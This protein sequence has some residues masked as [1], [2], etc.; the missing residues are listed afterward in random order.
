MIGLG[1]ALGMKVVGEGVETADQL[2][3]LVEL[4]CDFAQGFYVAHPLTAT[5][6]AILLG[7]C[8]ARPVNDPSLSTVQWRGSNGSGS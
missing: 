1:H 4:G 2:R 3:R 6:L 5:D 8:D 7:T